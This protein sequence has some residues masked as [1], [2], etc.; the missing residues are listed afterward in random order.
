MCIHNI[1]F[2]PEQNIKFLVELTWD[3]YESIF[4]Q[5]ENHSDVYKQKYAIDFSMFFNKFDKTQRW[6]DI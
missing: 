1:L 5:S 6:H 4:W 3:K 2:N